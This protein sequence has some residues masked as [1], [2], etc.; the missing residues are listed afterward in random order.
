MLYVVVA[1]SNFLSSPSFSFPLLLSPSQ[2]TVIN[3][4]REKWILPLFS[5]TLTLFS[6]FF[7]VILPKTQEKEMVWVPT[8]S[9][10]GRKERCSTHLLLPIDFSLKLPT[11]PIKHV[12]Q[13]ERK[14]CSNCTLAPSSHGFF[15]PSS[16]PPLLCR[17]CSCDM[18]QPR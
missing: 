14:R 6:F 3:H 1:S 15:A 16:P 12:L 18:S 4:L 2:P 17:L 10:K 8:M 5:L 9:I 11:M 7:P 13:H